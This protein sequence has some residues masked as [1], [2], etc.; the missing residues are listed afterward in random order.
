MDRWWSNPTV[1]I[2]VFLIVAVVSALLGTVQVRKSEK[3][4][5]YNLAGVLTVI[6]TATIAAGHYASMIHKTFAVAAVLGIAAGL[7]LCWPEFRNIHTRNHDYVSQN[8]TRND[9]DAPD[10]P[11]VDH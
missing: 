3:S 11:A 8:H 1:W 4:F 7:R 5:M 10:R 6:A 2:V 9:E